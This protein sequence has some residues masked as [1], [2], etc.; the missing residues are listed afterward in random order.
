MAA[1]RAASP[2]GTAAPAHLLAPLLMPR[3]IALV[4]AS[5]K[6]ETVGNG[7]IRAARGGG[8]D[9]RLYLINPNYPEIDGLACYPS[10]AALPETVDHV[11]LGVANARLEGQL[12]EAAKHGARAATIFASCYLPHDGDPPLTRRLSALARGAGMLLCGGNGMGFYNLDYGL[13]ICGFP[14]PDWI[15]PGEMTLIAHSGSVFSALCHN[16]KRFRYN[17]AVS[18]GQEL[19]TNAADYLDFALE[20]P[21]TRVVG[22]FLEAVRDPAGFV[23]ALAKAAERDIPVVCL[24]V[25]RTAE[26]A[27]LAVSHSGALAGDHAA[28]RAVCERHGVVQVDNLDEFAN[29]LLLLGQPRRLRRGGLASMHD[30]GGEREL[31]VDLAVKRGVPFARINEQTTARLAARLE[32]GLEP[33]N[34]LD[35]WGTGHDYEGIMADCLAALMDDPDTAVGTFFVET[36]SGHYLHEGY[37]RVV[38][39]VAAKT[40]KPVLIANNL[41]AVG[42]DDLALRVT[43]AGIPLLI[44][45]EPAMT[46]IRGAMDYRDFR[47]LPKLQPPAAP[48]GARTKWQA[49]LATGAT[50]DEAESLRLFA[51]YG[52][53]V[54]PHRI[55]DSADAAAAAAKELG[56]PVVLKTAMPGFL[57]KSDVGGVKL[58]LADE[59]AVRA[60]WAELSQRLGPRALVMSMAGKGVELA[61]GAVHDPQFGPLVMA[62]AGGI[63]IELIADR[64][65]ALPPFDAPAARRLIDGLGVRPLLDGKRGLPAAD[66]GAVAEALA[67]FSVMVADLAGLVQEIDVNP[68]I[69][70]PQGCVALDALVVPRA[71]E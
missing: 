55:V 32:F 70:S 4:G 62:G 52:L 24:K 59:Q 42:D 29:A 67:R 5:P 54:L 44:G 38:Q 23:A 22:L 30:S 16:D 13:R 17:L 50:L 40:D 57:H 56:F 68:L 47:A 51:D 15:E 20:Q 36:R 45:L 6:Q 64:R 11:V 14:P 8:F 71:A 65:F 25:G 60:A 43:R 61:F 49:R 41:A 63:L 3:S 48:A 58:G 21:T 34:P 12:A 18:A 53:P 66:V 9:G 39:A 35:A 69:C 26:S 2:A 37:A 28:F 7:M 33:I 31:T 1:R 27:A 10:L 19:V 46:A